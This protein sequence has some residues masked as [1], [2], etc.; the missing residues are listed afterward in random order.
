MHIDPEVSEGVDK[1]T[2]AEALEILDRGQKFRKL[3]K[4]GIDRMFEPSIDREEMCSLLSQKLR[5]PYLHQ[6]SFDILAG[7]Y[8]DL[9]RWRLFAPRKRPLSARTRS[10][11]QREA[12]ST[13]LHDLVTEIE[14]GASN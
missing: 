14:K 9:K 11:S 12:E 4:R 3:S 5:S 6:R 7:Y 1:K 2:E 10:K 13:D 8:M